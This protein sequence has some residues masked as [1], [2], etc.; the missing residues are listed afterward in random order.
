MVLNTE[1]TPLIDNKPNFAQ[2]DFLDY[3]GQV[4]ENFGKLDPTKIIY[5]D[6]YQGQ[7]NSGSEVM[8]Q[9]LYVEDWSSAGG[10]TKDW[11]LILAYDKNLSIVG[12]T[13]L[14]LTHNY[15]QI[16][17][18]GYVT[19]AITGEGIGSMMV[20]VMKR[21]FEE[22]AT[23]HK[24]HDTVSIKAKPVVYTIIDDHGDR[25]TSLEQ[26]VSAGDMQASAHL[27]HTQA[28]RPMWEALFAEDDSGKI[29]RVPDLE[30]N[31]GF[32]R[33]TDTPHTSAYTIT[34]LGNR[35]MAF[36][37]NPQLNIAA[38]TGIQQYPQI[39][40]KMEQIAV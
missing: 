39:K 30:L 13:S 12:C 5:G 16:D 21:N 11:L 26:R 9:P 6:T 34:R 17:A 36:Q 10:K 38:L 28:T 32:A 3:F 19:S 35:Q 8:L 27:H 40:M 1:F 24:R 31:R 15:S 22:I 7:R 18:Q 29:L 20:E 4:K 37:E 25:L 14:Y 23:R 33:E 2:K